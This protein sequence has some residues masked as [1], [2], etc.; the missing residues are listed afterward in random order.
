MVNEFAV[1]VEMLYM[2][3]WD[4]VG[5]VN[6]VRRSNFYNLINIKMSNKMV[7]DLFKNC[8]AEIDGKIKEKAKSK[9]KEV[10]EKVTDTKEEER[11]K[12]Q[13]E[14]K[15]LKIKKIKDELLI[16]RNELEALNKKSSLERPDREK[17]WQNLRRI[18]WKYYWDWLT[19]NDEKAY[20]NIVMTTEYNNYIN[21]L[22]I[23]KWYEYTFKL[24][25]G[26]KEM[27]NIIFQLQSINW[28]ELGIDIP[29][30]FLN[31]MN[32]NIKDWKIV[33]MALP[34]NNKK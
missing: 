15:E 31:S 32:V 24:A 5:D 9:L 14:K 17:I 21:W 29:P 27:R 28:Q 7:T 19:V 22:D 4:S 13:M 25:S 20:G 26:I 11:I 3:R 12:K 10:Y 2:M 34:N 30:A 33:V 18:N 23:K 16:H 6:Q 1:Y 8:V